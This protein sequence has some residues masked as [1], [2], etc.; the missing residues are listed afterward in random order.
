MDIGL[1]RTLDMPLGRSVQWLGILVYYHILFGPVGGQDSNCKPI[2]WGDIFPLDIG[3]DR[4]LDM[5]PG[6][7]V[8]WLGTLVYDHIL[9]GPVA[10]THPYM[11]IYPFGPVN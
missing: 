4:T 8:K 7:S 1:D 10:V 11:I 5:P 2:F 3:L 9:F 6:R